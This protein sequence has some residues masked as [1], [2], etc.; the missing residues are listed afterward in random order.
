MPITVVSGSPR[1][2]WT[3]IEDAAT[4]YTG[5]LVTVNTSAPTEGI[6]MLPDSAG[7]ANVTNHDIPLGVCI[8]NNRRNQLFNSTYKCTYITDPGATDAH[9]GASVEYF[10]QGNLDPKGD[11]I[12][13]AKVALI[14]PS[15][16]LRASLYNAAV[17]TAPTVV[18]VTT[19][20]TDGLGCTTGAIDF[21]AEGNPTST[22]QFRTGAN[23]GA[24]RILDSNSTTVHT[25]DKAVVTDVAIGDTAVAVPVRPFG[26]STVMFDATTATYID[27][28]DAPVLAG[29]DRW[30]INVITLKLDEAGNE[31]VEFTFDI[32]HFGAY[33]TNA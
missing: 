1:T 18:T 8:G 23:A 31:Y 16:V 6:T 13:M 32:G 11:E 15:T 14:T 22:F 28:A 30:S 29:T 2:I 19:G 12:A 21:T 9:D 33:V 27:V 10:T 25:W 24:R 26:P 17:G 5:G 3:P 7:V 4:I 20:N